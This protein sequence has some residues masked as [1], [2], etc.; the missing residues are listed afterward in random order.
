M[1]VNSILC[2]SFIHGALSH[3]TQ[4]RDTCR[5][6]CA[7]DVVG[8][9]KANT[10]CPCPSDPICK[11]RADCSSFQQITIEPTTVITASYTTITIPSGIV[12]TYATGCDGCKAYAEACSCWGITSTV[13]TASTPTMTVPVTV[14]EYSPCGAPLPPVCDDPGV[15]NSLNYIEDDRC[16]DEGKCTCSYDSSGNAVCV[17]DVDCDDADTCD[18]DDDCEGDLAICWPYSCCKKGVCTNLSTVCTDTYSARLGF[19]RDQKALLPAGWV[20]EI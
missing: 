15:C 11:H 7:R 6:K 12:P 4:E 14:T 1:K 17:E 19:H 8:L 20:G 16:G 10:D 18:D 5:N 3:I 13:I 2:L 9:P